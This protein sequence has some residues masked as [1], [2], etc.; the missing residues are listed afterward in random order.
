MVVGDYYADLL[1]NDCLILELK[2]VDA[3]NDAHKAQLVNYLRATGIEFG[4]ILN[5]GP[6]PEIARKVNSKK[7]K[8]IAPSL[9]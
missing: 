6:K 1:V 8:E 7:N 2:S 4:L 3:K 9:P 5:F